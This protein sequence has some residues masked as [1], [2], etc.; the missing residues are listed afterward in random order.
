MC[1]SSRS[2]T[3]PTQ[4]EPADDAARHPRQHRHHAGEGGGHL[5]KSGPATHTIESVARRQMDFLED[6]LPKSD[7]IKDAHDSG[8]SI[9]SLR[10]TGPTLEVLNGVES[11][12]YMAWRRLGSG[13]HGPKC[14]HPRPPSS[15]SGAGIPML[16]PEKLRAD[17]AAK[18]D[19]MKGPLWAGAGGATEQD[20]SSLMTTQPA[21]GR[22]VCA[23]SSIAASG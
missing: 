8:E 22:A 3:A 15:T 6:P 19:R 10:R 9:W 5:R 2:R 7:A 13:S 12:A 17:L 18:A 23:G 20:W 21:F 1:C 16:D 14:R 11:L 4:R